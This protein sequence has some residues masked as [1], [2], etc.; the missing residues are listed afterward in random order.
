MKQGEGAF[1]LRRAFEEAGA[2]Y[3]LSTLWTNSDDGTQFF[4]NDFYNLVLKVGNPQ[5]ALRTN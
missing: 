4:M 2:H 5:N 1:G 3:A